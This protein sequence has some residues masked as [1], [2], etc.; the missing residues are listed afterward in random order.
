ML[1][2]TTSIITYMYIHM[3][4]IYMYIYELYI[5][6]YFFFTCVKKERIVSSCE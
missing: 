3:Y 6:F 1:D 2:T 4:L 5:I